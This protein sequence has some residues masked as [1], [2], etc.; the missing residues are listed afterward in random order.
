MPAWSVPGVGF[1][2]NGNNLPVGA[3]YPERFP[4]YDW[5][6]DRA[7]RMAQRLGGD[8][9]VTLA[10]M[11]SV[12]NDVYARA[13]ERFV[14]RLLACA[15]SAAERL[16]P[17]A[18]AALDTLR[19][20]DFIAARDRVA[21]ALFRSWLAAFTRQAGLG[22][23]PGLTAA[24]LDGRAPAA[25]RAPQLAVAALDSALVALERRLGPDMGRWLW[26]RVHRARFDHRLA[27]KDPSF[28]PLTVVVDGDRSSPAVAPSELPGDIHVTHGPAWRHLVDL[29]VAD[30][31][32]CVIPPGNAGDG[33]H[34]RDHLQPWANHRYAPLHLSRE[35]IDALKE[36]EWRLIP[37]RTRRRSTGAAR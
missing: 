2:V 8:P 16:S 15:D 21:P 10:D 34:A 37:S 1:V 6:H 4:R 23:V 28:S 29:A 12:Q 17:R 35:R 9:R 7:A 24:V 36:S 20:W 31:S 11:R 18:R 3:P 30:S 22:G 25:V 26:G 14:P 27:W 33:P 5:I 19:R 32:L 13:A